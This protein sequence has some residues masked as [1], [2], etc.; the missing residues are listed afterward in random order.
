[1]S[2]TVEVGRGWEF[3]ARATLEVVLECN[4]LAATWTIDVDLTSRSTGLPISGAGAPVISEQ[5]VHELAAGLG[6]SYQAGLGLVGETL[7]LRYRLP[8]LWALVQDLT[9]P[10]WQARRAAAETITLSRQ[11]AAFVDGQLAIAARRGRLTVPAVTGAVELA[12]SRFEPEATRTLEEQALASRGVWFDPTPQTPAVTD[13]HARLDTLDAQALEATIAD[14]AVT[15]GRLGDPDTLSV[16]RATALG[17]LA[18]PQHSVDLI[19]GDT[20][21]PTHPRCT[22]TLF[23]HVDADHLQAGTGGTV[24]RLGAATWEVLAGWLARVGTVRVQPVLDLARTDAVDAHDPPTWM[25]TLVILRDRHCVFPGCRTDARACGLDHIDPYQSPDHLDDPGPPGQTHPDN[26]APLCRR[27]HNQKTHH[28]WT[29]IRH[30]DG[31]TWTSPHGL[32]HH[33]PHLTSDAARPDTTHRCSGHRRVQKASHSAHSACASSEASGASA[34]AS[35]GLNRSASRP[36]LRPSSAPGP[37]PGGRP[38]P[39][40]AAG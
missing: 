37:R 32:T 40:P 9:L 14:L 26:L 3:D 7:E 22:A 30:P 36:A 27:H 6:I 29:Y 17:I 16:R 13:L 23:V 5:G 19:T 33:V 10:A 12:R 28:G 18:D 24:E 39:A 38:A 31:Y 8:K 2:S 15:L 34:D 4:A 1:M 20:T 35:T 25:Q 21:E 11:A